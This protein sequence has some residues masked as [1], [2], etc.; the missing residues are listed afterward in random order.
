LKTDPHT[1]R[2]R[3][4][5]ILSHGDLS[6]QTKAYPKTYADFTTQ[7]LLT[8]AAIGCFILI[9]SF[10]GKPVFDKAIDYKQEFNTRSASINIDLLMGQRF[11]LDYLLPKHFVE[12]LHPNQA[13]L[14]T[15]PA[16]YV[17]KFIKNSSAH[18]LLNPIYAFYMN[19]AI[20]TV[21]LAGNFKQANCTVLID[22]EGNCYPYKIE[23][24]EDLDFVKNL[25]LSN[26]PFVP[27]E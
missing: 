8:L 4:V 14:L 9:R 11:G 18:S 20:Q 25:F 19:N 7:S 26:K 12:L 22:G 24:S 16:D 3:K 23:K 2:V 15:P 10:L 21:T 13:V 6:V 27:K 5:D 17:K 1:K